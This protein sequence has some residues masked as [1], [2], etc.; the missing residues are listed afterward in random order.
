[1]K[2]LT[3]LLL[4]LCSLLALQ[5][6][7]PWKF[8]LEGG[9][10][11]NNFKVNKTLF[12]SD[13]RLGW[14]VGPK[15][16]VNIP[17]V[18]IGFDVAALY[19][20]NNLDRIYIPGQTSGTIEEAYEKTMHTLAI[21]LNVRYNLGLSKVFAF[22]FAAGPQFNW[23]FKNDVKDTIKDVV[24]FEDYYFGINAGMGIGLFD[25]LEVGFNYNFALGEMGKIDGVKLKGNAW[26]VRMAVFF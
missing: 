24:S 12:T 2:R 5:A 19:N 26:N 13:N 15:F 20:H 25:R 6:A 23:N 21:P 4:L 10:N 1:M 7:K 3:T 11:V 8:G 16:K 14:F 18:N 17:V 9:M 22:Y